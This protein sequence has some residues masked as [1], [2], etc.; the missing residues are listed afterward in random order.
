M[1]FLQYANARSSPRKCP[2]RGA[3]E[4]LAIVAAV[5]V[6]STRPSS[7]AHLK[8]PMYLWYSQTLSSSRKLVW[9]I[10][11]WKSV[12]AG[13]SSCDFP[14]RLMR[15]PNLRSISGIAFFR[16]WLL[17]RHEPCVHVVVKCFLSN[18]R[19]Q[20]FTRWTDIFEPIIVVVD[21]LLCHL[22]G[23]FGDSE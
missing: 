6:S 10:S 16:Y 7:V 12:G 5:C 4:N 23:I 22:C 17:G 1:C 8:I 15:L 13:V 19:A 20:I 18:L 11:G 3:V 14:K 2:C 9:S 21:Q